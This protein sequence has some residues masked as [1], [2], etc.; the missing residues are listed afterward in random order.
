MSEPIKK[1]R[2]GD[3][4]K[5]KPIEEDGLKWCACTVPNLTS[6]GGGRGQA[7]CLKCG[8]PWYH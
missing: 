3:N 6:N 1:K 8:F 7:Y 4:G 5:R 2:G